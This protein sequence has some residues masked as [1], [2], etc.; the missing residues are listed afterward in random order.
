M[1]WA[2]ARYW[3]LA[4]LGLVLVQGLLPV[5]TGTTGWIYLLA[6]APLDLYYLY[7]AWCL[8]VDYSDG[9]ARSAFAWSILYLGLLF[10]ALLIDHF[11]FLPV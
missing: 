7:V 8:R 3:T 11:L 10:T 6:V 4:W 1:V 9:R 5:A 2:A